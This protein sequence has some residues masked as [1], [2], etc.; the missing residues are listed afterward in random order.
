M[1]T[2]LAHETQQTLSFKEVRR[3]LGESLLLRITHGAVVKVPEWQSLPV[4]DKPMGETF[5][6]QNAIFCCD[7]PENQPD[8]IIEVEPNIPWAEEHFLERVSGKPYNPPPSAANWPFAQKGHADHTKDEKFSHTYPERMWPKAAGRWNMGY[9][10]GVADEDVEDRRLVD[11]RFTQVDGRWYI[12]NEGIRFK[13]GDLGDVVK[14][15]ARSPQTRQAYLPIWFPEDTG[16]VH[17]ERVPC[18]LGY[19]FLIRAGQLHVTYFI[20]SCDFLRHFPDDVYMAM[21]LGQWVREQLGIDGETQTYNYDMGTL[22]M[23]MVS[24]HIFGGDIPKMKR[25]YGKDSD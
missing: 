3:E 12:M 18:S 25:E 23:H 4:E 13:L 9:R 24:L 22:T 15:L 17:G 2:P 14:Q 7:I 1:Y 20:R 16:A 5:E 10:L 19:H 11:E 8:T 21:R 6:L